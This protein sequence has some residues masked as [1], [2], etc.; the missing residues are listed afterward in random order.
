M[1][2]PQLTTLAARTGTAMRLTKGESLKIV[3]IHGTQVVRSRYLGI[4]KAA[5]RAIHLGFPLSC[6]DLGLHLSAS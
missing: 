2:E 5:N 1:T 3:N 4:T 6:R